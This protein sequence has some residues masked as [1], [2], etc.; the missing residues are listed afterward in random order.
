MRARWYDPATGEFL[1]VD[2]DFNQTLDAYGYGNEN[3]LGNIDP[4]GKGPDGDN[5]EDNNSFYC[6]EFPVE[7]PVAGLP[8]SEVAHLTTGQLVAIKRYEQAAGAYLAAFQKMIFAMQNQAKAQKQFEW[9]STCYD[10]HKCTSSQFLAAKAALGEAGYL[11]TQAMSAE[12]NAESNLEGAASNLQKAMDPD[13]QHGSSLLEYVVDFL[14]VV[15]CAGAMAISSA[16]DA[17]PV[18]VAACAAIGVA[19]TAYSVTKDI[20]N[21]CPIGRALFDGVIGLVATGVGA[22]VGYGGIKLGEMLD[23]ISSTVVQSAVK[24]GYKVTTDWPTTIAGASVGSPAF[25]ACN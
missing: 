21:G 9:A 12:Y 14:Q 24:Y 17:E 10:A 16:A 13:G 5:S 11:Q 23:D 7:C 22:L 15:G 2:P 19:G 25:S 8:L 1:S 4:S 20:L 6:Q 18:G 3:P